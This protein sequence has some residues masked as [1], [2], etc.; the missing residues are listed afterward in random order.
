MATKDISTV[1]SGLW[2][3][4]TD[5][6]YLKDWFD[7]FSPERFGWMNAKFHPIRIE[8]F[9]KGD[10]I[11]I[12]VELP[13]IDPDKD[14][15]IHVGDGVLTVSGERKEETK[16]EKRS[17]FYYGSFTRTVPLPAG[18]TEKGVRAM[19]KD[20]ILEVRVPAPHESHQS[21]RI[22]IEKG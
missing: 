21:K 17:E 6:P 2:K 5:F 9:V 8:E 1:E 14:V 16:T 11:V 19:Y 20:G 13:G 18:T 12:R 15:H 22:M 3:S 10:E 4:L 7:D